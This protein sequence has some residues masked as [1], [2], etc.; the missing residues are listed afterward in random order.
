[1]IGAFLSPMFSMTGAKSGTFP[2][3]GRKGVCKRSTEWFQNHHVT[4][5]EHMMGNKLS[6]LKSRNSFCS[7]APKLR[8]H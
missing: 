8:R 6:L 4:Q 1:M 3:Q 7:S 2:T 5:G